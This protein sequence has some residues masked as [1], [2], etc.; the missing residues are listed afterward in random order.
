MSAYIRIVSA[1][2]LVT[3]VIL[4]GCQRGTEAAT[5]EVTVDITGMA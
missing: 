5:K 2:L 1:L 3:L 4:A